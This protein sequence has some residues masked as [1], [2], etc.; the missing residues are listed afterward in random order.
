MTIEPAHFPPGQALFF[1]DMPVMELS[2]P[3]PGVDALIGMDI[4]LMCKLLLDGPAKQFTL[5]W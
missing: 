1:P 4:L 5:E 3:I 2:P